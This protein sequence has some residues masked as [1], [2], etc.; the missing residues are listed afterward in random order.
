MF[1]TDVTF[2]RKVNDISHAIVAVGSRDTSKAAEFI[3]KT[4]PKGSRAQLDGHCDKVPEACGSYEQ[5][6]AHP[7]N[8]S[9]L[10]ELTDL[11]CADCLHRYSTPRAFR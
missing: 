1:C 10:S 8:R 11:G 7:V 2:D 9:H 4:I 3:R 6:Y 5:V